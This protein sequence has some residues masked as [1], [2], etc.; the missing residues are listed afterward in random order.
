[1]FQGEG[2][3]PELLRETLNYEAVHLATRSYK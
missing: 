3:D 1:M 2:T